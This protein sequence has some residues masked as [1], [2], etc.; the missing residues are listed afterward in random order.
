[1]PKMKTHSGASKRFKKTGTGKYKRKKAG[2]GH[3][4]TKKT[5]RKKRKLGKATTV[6]KTQEK[7]VEQMLPY[8]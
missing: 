6:D 7:D 1:M 5:S 2:K 3:I 8:K 4:L